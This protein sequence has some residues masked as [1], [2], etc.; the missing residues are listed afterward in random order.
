MS[1]TTSTTRL[2][3]LTSTVAP[4]TE[5]DE[6]SKTTVISQENTD[7]N[8]TPRRHEHSKPYVVAILIQLTALAFVTSITTGIM[9]VSIPR[10]AIDL[11]IQPQL[12]YW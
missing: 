8:I 3:I 1:Y 4:N 12:Y 11:A 7:V 2:Q 6:N 5:A 10:I 9:N